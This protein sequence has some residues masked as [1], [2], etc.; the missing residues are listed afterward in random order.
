MSEKQAGGSESGRKLTL[1]FGLCAVAFLVLVVFGGLAVASDPEDAS[2]EH[3]SVPPDGGSAP[4]VVAE[5][6]NKRTATSRTF[7]LSDGQLETRVY[8]TPVNYRDA[9]GGWQPIGQE[10]QQSTDGAVSNG[11]N[12][13]D[14]QLPEDLD[15]APA[16]LST[17]GE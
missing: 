11:S 17:D 12:S 15:R 6:K 10:L 16:K 5:V 7:R 8:Q 1:T 3:S 2:S 13:F 4:A 14:V 9:E